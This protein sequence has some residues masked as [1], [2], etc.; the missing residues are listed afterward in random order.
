VGLKL[1]VTT[2]VGRYKLMTTDGAVADAGKYILI[3]HRVDGKWLL[4]RDII[5][6]NNPPRLKGGLHDFAFR[7][8]SILFIK[9]ALKECWALGFSCGPWRLRLKTNQVVA[10]GHP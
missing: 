1:S 6:T 4:H 7:R 8:N 2:E 10:A 9:S 3:W 5:N